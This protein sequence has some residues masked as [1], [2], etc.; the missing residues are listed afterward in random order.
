MK[1]LRKN[2]KI[3][4]SMIGFISFL[5]WMIWGNVTIDVSHF[6]IADETFP[7]EFDQFKIAHISDLHSKNW[8]AT[9]VDLIQK[10]EPDIIAITGD[11]IDSNN[12]DV[13]IAL[14]FV[15]QI[16]EFAPIYFVSGN[17]EAW[18][19]L[20]FELEEKLT[21]LGVTILDNDRVVLTKGDEQ[22]LLAGLKDPAFYSESNLLSEQNNIV[23]SNL[24]ELIN[25]FEG[26]KLLLSHRPELFDMYVQNEIDLVLS[27]HAHGG[28]IRIP[29]IGGLVAPNQGFF[30]TYSAGR[31]IENNT[32]MIVSRGLGNS[33]LPVRVNNRPELVIITLE[34]E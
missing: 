12:Q 6:S 22:I 17:H 4:I 26:F 15:N 24:Q 19:D 1:T 3:I 9:L 13:N 33:I 2:K 5:L 25:D 14:E 21:E 7:E 23:E 8:G 27:G 30:P 16:R 32:N 34:S 28:Q 18:S 20:Y 11:L 29:L 10:E 31:Y